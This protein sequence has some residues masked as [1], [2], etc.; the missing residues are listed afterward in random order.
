MTITK[1]EAIARFRRSKERKRI[2]VEETKQK[3]AMEYLK[4]F[5]DSK[6]LHFE[7]S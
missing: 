4:M 3:L 6:N 5:P 2:S 1:D 7:V